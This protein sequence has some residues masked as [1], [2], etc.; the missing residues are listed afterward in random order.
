MGESV[1]SV[2]TMIDVLDVFGLS[3][4]VGNNPFMP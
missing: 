4:A 2:L 3:V 1:Y